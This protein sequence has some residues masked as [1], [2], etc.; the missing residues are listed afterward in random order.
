MGR[1]D[2]DV[3][4][5][6]SRNDRPLLDLACLIPDAEN[7]DSRPHVMDGLDPAIGY[8]SQIANDAIPVG[9][10][11]MEMT[12]S[13]PVMTRLDRC[14][15]YVNSKGGCYKSCVAADS[16]PSKYPAAR[17]LIAASHCFVAPSTELVRVVCPRMINDSE[18]WVRGGS[19]LPQITACATMTAP[20]IIQCQ[21]MLRN[22]F[23]R[24]TPI[25]MVR[26]SVF[27]GQSPSA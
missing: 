22:L 8:L 20:T 6:A 17:G 11:P 18:V 9:N 25:D 13:S 4:S 10:H 14:V 23:G 19:R 7:T 24:L 3:Q 15:Q 12:R 1:S 21:S 5:D 27:H 26:P 2:G 16:L